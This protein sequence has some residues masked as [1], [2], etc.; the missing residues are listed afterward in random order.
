[1]AWEL[2]QAR[3]KM[4]EDV[5]APD[6]LELK[7]F[8]VMADQLGKF[9]PRLVKSDNKWRELLSRKNQCNPLQ[10]NSFHISTAA[11]WAKQIA[12][13]VGRN[14]GVL[15]GW[16]ALTLT[17]C[18]QSYAT[19]VAFPI[20]G[21][22]STLRALFGFPLCKSTWYLVPNIYGTYSSKVPKRLSTKR[23]RETLQATDR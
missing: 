7:C 4:A 16:W 12:E 18:A 20:H 3:H 1:M 13:D 19:N 5:P 21:T 22:G 9:I 14:V 11:V 17:A 15:S 23:C 2:I 8:L 6:H 10:A